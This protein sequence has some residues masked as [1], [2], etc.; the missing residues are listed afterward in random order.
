[1][2]GDILN[3]NKKIMIGLIV[4]SLGI[5]GILIATP[6]ISLISIPSGTSLIIY[7]II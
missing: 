1:V 6:I 3:K 2:K 7:S 4:I 5:I